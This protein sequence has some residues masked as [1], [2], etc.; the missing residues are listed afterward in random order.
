MEAAGG[1]DD[2]GVE[3]E[4]L[5]RGKGA[6]RAGDGIEITLG[7]VDANRR[8]LSEHRELLDGRGTPHVGRH[9]DRV[10]PLTGEP[11]S[12]LCA[13]GCFTGALKTEEQDD[14]GRSLRVGKAAL[15]IAEQREHLVPHDADDVLHGR[16]AL[17]HLVVD[18][19]VADLV[20]ERLD[21]LEVD[22]RLEQRHPDLTQRD[23]D[24]LGRETTLSANVAEDVL[25]AFAE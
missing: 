12:E 11:S 21:D 8:L 10:P 17:E 18:R 5:G 13:G 1:V 23:L 4:R 14:A 20:D 2:D 24:G 15:G 19:R 9:H 22:V 25:E 7:I 3:A 16:Q 6:A